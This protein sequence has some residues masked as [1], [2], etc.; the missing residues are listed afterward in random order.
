[1][2]KHSPYYI[3]NITICLFSSSEKVV[4]RGSCYSRE[5]EERGRQEKI[6]SCKRKMNKKEISEIKKQFSPDNC[7]ITRICGCYV[8][9]EKNKKTKVKEAFRLYQRKRH[10]NIS[11]F[12][13]K[14]CPAQ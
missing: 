9:V 3:R 5:K 2:S 11:R 10:S 8:D 7:Y 13:K 1:M 4:F 12:S 14:R 6:F